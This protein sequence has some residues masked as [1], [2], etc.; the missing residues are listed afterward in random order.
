MLVEVINSDN[1]V[2]PRQG[3]AGIDLIAADEG[4]VQ[5]DDFNRPRYI[6]YKTGVRLGINEERVHGFV[7]PRSSISNYDLELANSVAV[8]DSN[9]QG[10]IKLR[11]RFLHAG[12]SAFSR[13]TKYGAN[14][15]YKKGDKI[16]QLIFFQPVLPEIVSVDSFNEQTERGEGGFGSTGS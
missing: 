3:D 11:F 8:I 7:F 6:E 16:A 13:Q 4:S 1:L 15:V 9:Y 14:K 12:F 10:E 5:F 2:L